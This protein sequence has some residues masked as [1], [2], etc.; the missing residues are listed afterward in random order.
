MSRVAPYCKTISNATHYIN[1]RLQ[2]SGHKTQFSSDRGKAAALSAVTAAAGCPAE[3]DSCLASDYP[4]TRSCSAAQP[5][6]PDGAAAAPP[7][8][9]AETGR[10]GSLNL[11]SLAWRDRTDFRSDKFSS[12]A[13]FLKIV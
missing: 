12:I 3:H 2:Y 11:G 13:I 9:G 4:A 10:P 1:K 7:R 5:T 8:P 6:G